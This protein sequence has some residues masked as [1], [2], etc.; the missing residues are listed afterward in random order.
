[1]FIYPCHT[2]SNGRQNSIYKRYDGMTM[3]STL[4]YFFLFIIHRQIVGSCLFQAITSFASLLLFYLRNLSYQSV[5]LYRIFGQTAIGNRK[6]LWLFRHFSKV[7]QKQRFWCI[8]FC[9]FFL[10][11][12]LYTIFFIIFQKI[13]TTSALGCGI[14][15]IRHPH[16]FFARQRNGNHLILIAIF[17][18]CNTSIVTLQNKSHFSQ[19][20]Y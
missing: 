19:K 12:A 18:C 4:A 8:R 11:N 14:T 20:S 6:K 5:V 9:C 16:C 17:S 15:A 13:T 1:M 2:R 7:G 10:Y 3:E